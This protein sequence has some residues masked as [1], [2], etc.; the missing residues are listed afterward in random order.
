MHID[1]LIIDLQKRR[2]EKE[3]QVFRTP[4]QDDRD[5]AKQLGIWLGLGEALSIL[6]DVRKKE[7]DD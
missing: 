5:F 2:I 3:G 4:P 7:K 6:E 1:E